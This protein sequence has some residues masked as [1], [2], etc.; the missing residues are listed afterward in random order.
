MRRKTGLAMSGDRIAVETATARG[1]PGARSMPQA[2]LLRA[3]VMIEAL[4]ISAVLHSAAAVGLGIPSGAP[5][6]PFVLLFM[7]DSILV[8]LALVPI[9]GV[10][11]SILA[12]HD[13]L[14]YFGMLSLLATGAFFF[15]Y[16]WNPPFMLTYVAFLGDN[17]ANASQSTVL[18][19]FVRAVLVEAVF[20]AIV[21]IFNRRLRPWTYVRVGKSEEAY[22]A[23]FAG[24]FLLCL[25]IYGVLKL[26]GTSY[27]AQVI[28]RLGQPLT[29]PPGLARYFLLAG[30]AGSAVSLAAIGWLNV[31]APTQKNL[32]VWRSAVPVV[33]VAVSIVLAVLAGSRIAVVLAGFAAVATIR[34]FG[35]SLSRQLLI[36]LIALVL[37]VGFGVT[38][39]RA[40]PGSG[41]L[42][43]RI[44]SPSSVANIFGTKA[45]VSTLLLN[46]D[47]TANTALVVRELDTTGHYLEGESLVSGWDALAHDYAQRL[48]IASV[49]YSPLWLPNQYMT[50]W[51]FGALTD[52]S[53]VPPGFAGEFF[54]DFGYAGVLVLG[55]GFG[56]FV[57]FLRRRMWRTRSLAGRWCLVIVLFT[58][59]NASVTQTSVLA[60][61]LGL[62]LL[63]AAL[64]LVAFQ[65]IARFRPRGT[66]SSRLHLESAREPREIA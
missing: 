29:P 52:N 25:G 40:N 16:L 39:L 63:A 61:E 1:R 12:W 30:I 31:T 49:A 9:V 64:T 58:G 38:L 62:T 32:S 41:S 22:G 17:F 15:V 42:V 24:A 27:Y 26:R 54:M 6:F 23:A 51:R 33:L 21:L 50:Y 59:I 45:R 28:S 5:I 37:A 44:S 66:T 53:P 7:S 19:T 56:W 4:M 48:G 43:A 47:R 2:S 13:P 35:Y 11:R 60:S 65:F 18:L 34:H 55:A 20:L 3:P 36:G 46:M 8:A 14:T 10:R 57:A